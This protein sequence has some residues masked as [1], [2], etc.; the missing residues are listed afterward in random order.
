MLGASDQ[1]ASAHLSPSH[2]SPLA[3]G[4]QLEFSGWP[5]SRSGGRKSRGAG[6]PQTQSW[7]LVRLPEGLIFSQISNVER[8]LRPKKASQDVQGHGVFTK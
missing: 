8:I 6:R 3:P 5:H 1:L 2:G 4:L 7:D